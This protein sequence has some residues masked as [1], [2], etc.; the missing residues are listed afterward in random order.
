MLWTA[1]APCLYREESEIIEATCAD[2]DLVGLGQ[3]TATAV[4][5]VKD[6]RGLIKVN[7]API[8][9]LEPE[10]LRLKTFEPVLLLGQDAFKDVSYHPFH[11]CEAGK[12]SS[13]GSRP[14]PL[15]S[16]PGAPSCAEI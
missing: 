9:N 12:G 14:R 7:G 5:F 3:K 6:G 1:H 8:E 16:T 2:L 13:V 15:C 11:A 4:A 10:M